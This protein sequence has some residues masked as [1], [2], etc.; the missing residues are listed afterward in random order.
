MYIEIEQADKFKEVCVSLGELNRDNVEITKTVT[1]V[2]DITE[3]GTI[4]NIEITLLIP[5]TD[6]CELD[7]EMEEEDG[8]DLEAVESPV[9]PA[10]YGE[11]RDSRPDFQRSYGSAYGFGN[12]WVRSYTEF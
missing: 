8:E 12:S 3:R 6:A 10:P 5:H 4:V 2:Y 1:E 9:P 7:L 11:S